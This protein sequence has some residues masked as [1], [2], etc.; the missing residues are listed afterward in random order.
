MASSIQRARQYITIAEIERICAEIEARELRA[1]LEKNC[2]DFSG[3]RSK[4]ENFVLIYK[5]L[6]RYGKV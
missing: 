2:V 4:Y 1:L 3:V 5:K 6:Q